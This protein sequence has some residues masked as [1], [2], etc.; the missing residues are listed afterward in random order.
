VGPGHLD[1]LRAAQATRLLGPRLAVPIHWGTYSLPFKPA[2]PD[3]PES[4]RRHVAELAPDVE[5]R[6]LAPGAGLDF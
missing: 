1:P 3:P 6:V 4:F 2:P 5:V